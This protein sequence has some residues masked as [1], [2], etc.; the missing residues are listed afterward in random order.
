MEDRGAIPRLVHRIW[1]TG[2]PPEPEWIRPFADTWRRPR[3]TL[4]QWSGPEELQPLV[5]QELYDRAE[6]IAP[7][8]PS[9][10]R[11]DI[12]RYEIL[13]R[14]GGVYVDADFEC[15][16]PID[17]LL[18]GVRAFAAWDAQDSVLANGFM[19]GVPGHPFLGE[20]VRGLPASVNARLG[21]HPARFS[22]PRYLTQVWQECG[23]DVTVFPSHL[24]YPYSWEQTDAHVPGEDWPGA[25]AVHHW[26]AARAARHDD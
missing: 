21:P 13:H 15:L 4:R 8:H 12:L 25:Y 23:E 19:G 14:L 7:R 5:N 16:R 20:L 24:V 6:E 1:L 26:A 17:E 11:A 3:W 10:L 22:G 2:S 18:E 9:R